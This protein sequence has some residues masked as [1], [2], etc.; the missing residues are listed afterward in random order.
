MCG[1]VGY[2]GN[3]AVAEELLAGLKNLEYRGYDSA[4]IALNDNKK[5]AVFKASGKLAN[6]NAVLHEKNIEKYSSFMGIGH[7]RWATHGAPTIENAHPHLSNDG[8]LVLVHNGIIE[9]YK[10]LRQK[11][12]NQGVVFHSQT[13]TEVAVHLF[14]EEYKKCGSLEQAIRRGLPQLKG[15]FAFVIMHHN[16]SDKIIAVR[17]NAP[18]IIGCGKNE[19]YVA[20][21]IPALLGKVSY[22]IHLDDDEMAVVKKDEVVVKG[23]NGQVIHKEREKVDMAADVISKNGYAHFMLK[24][25]YE[26]PAILRKVM[27]AH[28]KNQSIYLDDA[29]VNVDFAK[30]QKIVI[31]ACGTSLHAAMVAKKVWEEWLHLPVLVEA[32]SEFIYQ[33]NLIDEQTLVIGVSQSGETADTIT[34]LK[35]A[36]KYKAQIMVLTNRVDSSIV[37]YA[38]S[39]VPLNAGVEISVAATKSYMAQLAAFY[40]F[41]LLMA[42]NLNKISLAEFKNKL[43]ILTQLPEKIEEIL[44]HQNDIEAIAQKLAKYPAVVFMARGFNLPTAYEAALKLKE[45]S[46]INANAYPAGELKHGPIALLDKNMPVLALFE[47]GETA[48]KLLSN[49]E[50]AKARHA[51]VIGIGGVKCADVFDEYIQTPEVDTSFSPLLLCVPVQLLA[52]FTAKVL[53]RE[54][55]QPRNLAKSVTVE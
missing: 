10:E 39:V 42:Q 21:D 47:G 31:V 14:A 22:I 33:T 51:P 45:I 19:N 2:I 35:L 55:D 43:N 3:N 52:Y 12:Q 38:S 30:V 26:Q 40:W 7:I 17:K 48:Q 13:D 28:V 50:E 11:L 20:S 44:S 8:N 6:L 54:I 9:N 16:E 15:A 37:R 25:I 29:K 5:I 18:L 34:A 24:E 32:A 1:I 41:G 23:I 53:N 46:Y 36:Q 4:G 49:C 27:Q